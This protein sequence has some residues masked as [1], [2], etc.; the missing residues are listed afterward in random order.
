MPYAEL[1]NSILK[2]RQQRWDTLL[3][4]ADNLEKGCI[5]TIA[6]NCAG[7]VKDSPV[8]RELI[9]HAEK[10]MAQDANALTI[11]SYGDAAGY[12]VFMRSS[13]KTA[14][15]KEKAVAIESSFEWNRLLDI[16]I[17]GK[18]GSP[19]DRSAMGLAP[20]RCLLCG[21]PAADCIRTQRHDYCD[22]IAETERLLKGFQR[23]CTGAH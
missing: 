23:A 16:D 3:N 11:G 15:A 21:E 2:A 12:I 10:H 13:L 7:A 9:T 14:Q 6:G 20:R 19:A 18:K 5:V 4:M 22:I 17:Y 1:R 8:L